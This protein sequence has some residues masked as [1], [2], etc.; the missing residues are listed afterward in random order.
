MRPRSTAII[1]CLLAAGSLYATDQNKKDDPN[2]VG[3]RDVV[4]CLNFYSVEKDI[5][6]GK[7][8]AEE[9]SRQDKVSRN[10]ILGEFVNRIGLN[11]VR[12]SDADVPFKFQVVD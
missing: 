12:S 10:A 3:N 7:Q 8:L 6:L 1:L 9:D 11:L 4:K 2:Q 5:A